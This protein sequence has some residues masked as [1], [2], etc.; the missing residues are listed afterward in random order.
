M[1]ALVASLIGA[2][3]AAAVYLMLRRRTFALV[4]G[5]TMMTYAVN[6]FLVSTGR[7]VVNMPPVLGGHVPGQ[8]DY[9]DPLPQALVLTA[10]VI[11]FG[12]TAVTVMMAIGAFVEAGNDRVDMPR[13]DRFG[14]FDDTG[15]EAPPVDEEGSGHPAEAANNNEEAQQ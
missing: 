9:T 10:I 3:V 7:L 8:S 13:A 12:M 6:L 11:S 2:L 1:E 14:P 15:G 4:L 5:S